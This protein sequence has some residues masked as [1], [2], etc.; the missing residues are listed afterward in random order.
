MLSDEQHYFV[1]K[2][3]EGKNVLVDACIGSGKT[4]AIQCA[5]DALPQTKNILYLTYNKLL[6]C[7]ARSK[8]LNKNVLVTNYHGFAWTMLKNQNISVSANTAVLKFNQIKPP[9]PKYDVMII[10]EYQDIETDLAEL[11]L[12]IRRM[13]PDMQI[14]AV[15][16][17]HQKI[18]DKTTLDVYPFI[19]KFLRD[20]IKLEFTKCFRLN[21]NLASQLGRIW[22]KTIVGVNEQCQVLDMTIPQAEMFLANQKLSD[23]L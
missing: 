3:L 14:V 19:T 15:G 22:N 18:Y 7:D 8:I 9:I 21:N 11:I 6:K 13:N 4:T 20:H 17:M 23:I 2:V 5:C 12:Y 16:D 10:D 1:N